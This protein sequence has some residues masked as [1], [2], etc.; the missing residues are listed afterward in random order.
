MR[1]ATG[2]FVG[3]MPISTG[4]AAAQA[5]PA[6]LQR[7]VAQ[8]FSTAG[9]DIVPGADDSDDSGDGFL[10][11][12]GPG[13]HG[14]E[15][16]AGETAS[17]EDVPSVVEVSSPTTVPE[18]L[19]DELFPP[20]DD[21]DDADDV[22]DA[23]APTP[24]TPVD[25]A[26]PAEPAPPTPG[27]PT[28]PTPPAPPVEE[29]PP[30][31]PVEEEP[32]APPVEEEPPAPPVEEEP[33]APPGGGEDAGPPAPGDGDDWSDWDWWNWFDDFGDFLDWWFSHSHWG[34]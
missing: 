10:L 5:L 1:L 28:P 29:E 14:D 33:P 13:D 19:Q 9:L 23:P 11:A 30:T 2:T 7:A 6:P 4:L 26:P 31:P 34:H 15:A 25:V 32:P 16:P 22:V 12:D 20:S 21:E 27:L 3:L 8:A 24:D 18:Q 17:D